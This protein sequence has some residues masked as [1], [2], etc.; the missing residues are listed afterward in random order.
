MEGGQI[1]QSGSFEELLSAGTTFEQ[2]VKAHKNAVSELVSSEL[3]LQTL[4]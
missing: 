1:M 4:M 3:K 2:L